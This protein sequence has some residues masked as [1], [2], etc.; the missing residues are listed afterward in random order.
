VHDSAGRF[1]RCGPL[2][3]NEKEIMT[4]L[5]DL[6]VLKRSGREI[7]F[8]LKGVKMVIIFRFVLII[9]LTALFVNG[10]NTP[11]QK[12]F[13][14]GTAQKQTRDGVLGQGEYSGKYWPT[15]EW[16]ECWPEAV[17][18]N[19][20][21]LRQAIE[22]AATPAFNTD[23]LVIIRKGHIVGEVYFGKF[24]IDSKHQ[25]ASMAKSF[26]STLVGIAVDKGLI[27]DIDERI[28]RYYREWDCNNQNDFRSRITIRHALTLTTGLEWQE[29]WSKWDPATNDALKMGQSGRFMK[30]M[31]ERKGLYEPGQRFY[32]STGDPMLL[33]R[34]IQA[35]TGVTVFEFAR[36]NLFKP[37]NIAN[38]DW[39][40]D[41]DGYTSTGWGLNTTVRDYA[42]FGYLF[43]NKGYWEDRRIVSGE[44]VEKS[45]Q[46]DPSVKMW[47]AYGYLWHVNLP[48]RL[49]FSRS[50]V[51]TDAIPA[52]GYMAEGVRGQNIFIIPSRDLVIVRV[53]NQ[54]R[55]AMDLVAFL[56]MVLNAIEK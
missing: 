32:Y 10:W 46:T 23:G 28:C 33:S 55:G 26:T 49:S 12:A 14:Q 56:T 50:P 35:V 48:L 5:R 18:M 19:S 54:T 31:A 7:R 34:V 53:A 42:K 36:Q 47:S 29:D 37:L 39:Q 40:E 27:K 25:S 22:Y 1:Y 8:F 3:R 30:Y 41:R 45:T 16:R 44:W 2:N 4:V 24:K 43:L 11:A 17:G 52:D 20:E 21:K 6:C 15:K 9:L 13:A 51:S 38:I